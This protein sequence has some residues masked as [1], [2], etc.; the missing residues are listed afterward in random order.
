[1][2]TL[3]DGKAVKVEMHSGTQDHRD[4]AASLE[5]LSSEMLLREVRPRRGRA[6]AYS[7]PDGPLGKPPD[8]RKETK[9]SPDAHLLT[10]TTGG[11]SSPSLAHS[12]PMESRC[13][14][15]RDAFRCEGSAALEALGIQLSTSRR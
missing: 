10:P 6:S 7:C 11:T 13:E 1:V 4:E 12:H 9:P 15:V 2:W 8:Q 14:D 3:R 5:S